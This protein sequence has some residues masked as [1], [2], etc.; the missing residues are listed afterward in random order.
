MTKE[1]ERHNYVQQAKP[2]LILHRRGRGNNKV[3]VAK[4][5]EALDKLSL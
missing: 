2:I 5:L 3:R 1:G 4:G